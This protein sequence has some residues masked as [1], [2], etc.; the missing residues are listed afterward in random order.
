[1]RFLRVDESILPAESKRTTRR[2]K[3]PKT[4]PVSPLKHPK[5]MSTSDYALKLYR[6]RPQ[7]A[8]QEKLDAWQE[9]ETSLGDIPLKAGKRMEKVIKT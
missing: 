3:N 4:V 5:L 9:R 2:F 8:L 7:I 1:M 6:H